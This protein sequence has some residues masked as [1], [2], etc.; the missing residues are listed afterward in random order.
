MVRVMLIYRIESRKDKSKGLYQIPTGACFSP[1]EVK[2]H[3]FQAYTHTDH[4]PT[5]E[6][7]GDFRPFTS[8]P[9]RFGFPT[10]CCM[11]QWICNQWWNKLAYEGDAI[12]S[13]YDAPPGSFLATDTQVLFMIDR[14]KQLFHLQ[15]KPILGAK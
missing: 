10:I 3:S 12:I 11:K 6:A 14:A 1:C 2:G 7:E 13:I 4:R 5:V 15:L 9:Y 8:K